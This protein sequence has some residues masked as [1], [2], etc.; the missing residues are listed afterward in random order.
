MLQ[1]ILSVA[2]FCFIKNVFKI[3][4]YQGISFKYCNVLF[5]EF[6]EIFFT[7]GFH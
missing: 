4:V 1:E 6:S 2:N 7:I 5:F 3:E